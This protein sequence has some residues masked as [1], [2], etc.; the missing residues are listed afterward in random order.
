MAQVTTRTE[1]DLGSVVEEIVVE[2]DFK[3]GVVGVIGKLVVVGDS[4]VRVTNS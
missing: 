4:L 1:V 3:E 2:E